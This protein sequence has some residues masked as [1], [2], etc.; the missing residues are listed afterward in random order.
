MNPHIRDEWVRR[1]M[2][3]KFPQGRAYLNRVEDSGLQVFCCLGVLTELGA[4]QGIVKRSPY[5]TAGVTG[6]VAVDNPAD[7]SACTLPHAVRKWAGLLSINPE[8][9][10]QHE[11]GELSEKFSLTLLNDRYQIP[12]GRLAVLIERQL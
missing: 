5:P 12:F 7:S 9:K 3:G 6:Y 8:I 2:S 11:P 4:E 10:A 1:L